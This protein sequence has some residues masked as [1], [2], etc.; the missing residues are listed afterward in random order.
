MGIGHDSPS[1]TAPDRLR[2]DAAI[3]VLGPFPAAHG[4]AHQV[5]PAG[6]Y[7]LTSHAG[8]YAE[9]AAAYATIFA[10]LVARPDLTVIGL[11]AVEV[12]HTTRIDPRRAMNHTDIYIPVERKDG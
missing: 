9:L 4:I 8:S 3:A 11:P 10:R 7:A 12:Y 5:V 6:A 2:F 1:T